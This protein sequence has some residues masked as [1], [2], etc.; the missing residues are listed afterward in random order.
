MIY[1]KQHSRDETIR[2][3]AEATGIAI[4]EERG[5]AIGEERGIA[6]GEERG[7]REQAIRIAKSM[8]EDGIPEDV[9][10]KHTGLSL[11]EIEAL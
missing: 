7:E 10:S 2:K 6:I 9:I 3:E 11:E 8:K 5:I 1:L 4:G